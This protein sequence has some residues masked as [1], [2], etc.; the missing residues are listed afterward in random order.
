[1][2]QQRQQRPA[3]GLTML[4]RGLWGEAITAVE[5]K[6]ILLGRDV[7]ATRDEAMISAGTRQ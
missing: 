6:R 7:G 3:I 1:M 5:A 4:R 2:R